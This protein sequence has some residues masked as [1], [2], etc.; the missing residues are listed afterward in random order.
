M[1]VDPDER[2]QKIMTQVKDYYQ[3]L[4]GIFKLYLR[5][6]EVPPDGIQLLRAECLDNFYYRIEKRLNLLR[7]EAGSIPDNSGA[8]SAFKIQVQRYFLE[9]YFHNVIYF[10]SLLFQEN[11]EIFQMLKELANQAIRYDSHFQK[12]KYLDRVCEEKS[13][14]FHSEF[15][16]ECRRFQDWVDEQVLNFEDQVLSKIKQNLKG[17]SKGSGLFGFLGLKNEDS[18]SK[19][20]E[21]NFFEK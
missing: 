7:E 5:S 1:E 10:L 8:V 13:K 2:N 19:D 4:E 17:K 15:T 21:I 11:S 9:E 16:V 12:F 6:N 3:K 14:R 20:D 18:K